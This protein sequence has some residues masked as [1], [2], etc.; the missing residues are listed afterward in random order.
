[1]QTSA[2]I[3]TRVGS[4]NKKDIEL[5]GKKVARLTTYCMTRK[6]A[7]VDVISFV[8]NPKETINR[9]KGLSKSGAFE[10]LVVLSPE[11]IADSKVEFAKT[12]EELMS[13]YGVQIHIVK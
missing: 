11:D 12:L 5:L 4:T 13:W 2:V 3:L 8:G 9:I 6:I 7:I 10:Y 1:M